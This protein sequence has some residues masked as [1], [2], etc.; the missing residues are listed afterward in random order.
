MKK[1]VEKSKEQTLLFYGKSSVYE[2]CTA[3][4]EDHLLTPVA[5]MLSLDAQKFFDELQEATSGFYFLEA[6]DERDL[7]LTRGIDYRNAQPKG[8]CLMLACTFANKS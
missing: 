1:A 7:G 4:P 5:I 6:D 2:A 3:F 8:I